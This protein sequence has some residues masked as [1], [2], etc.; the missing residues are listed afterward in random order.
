MSGHVESLSSVT[1]DFFCIPCRNKIKKTLG[2]SI[3]R[4][5]SIKEPVNP[6]KRA[7]ENTLTGVGKCSSKE[8]SPSFRNK[9]DYEG[10]NN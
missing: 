2:T 7:K 5:K 3:I 9:V 6:R 1:P 8:I 4:I 10:D